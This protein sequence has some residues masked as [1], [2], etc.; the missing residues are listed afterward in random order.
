VVVVRRC[1]RGEE[2][3]QLEFDVRPKWS[4]RELRREEEMVR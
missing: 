3:R 1:D 2:R 4:V